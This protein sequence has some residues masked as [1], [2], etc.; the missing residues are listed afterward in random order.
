[1]GGSPESPS[2]E[3]ILEYLRTL[4]NRIARIESHLKL[5]A[6]PRNEEIVTSSAPTI[7]S[8]DD[9]ELELRLGQNWFAKAGVVG[10]SLG[11]A[12]LLTLPH[13][14]LQGSSGT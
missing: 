5:E 13:N 11:I 12:F 9:E 3:Q 7:A 8:D 1:M 6:S 10:L 2:N 4:E 14:N